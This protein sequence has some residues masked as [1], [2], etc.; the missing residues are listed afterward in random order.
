MEEHGWARS[1]SDSVENDREDDDEFDELDGNDLED[2][3]SLLVVKAFSKRDEIKALLFI[4]KL[5]LRNADQVFKYLELVSEKYIRENCT[6]RILWLVYF[7]RTLL[8]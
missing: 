2:V 5:G 1:K 3:A 6:P 4:Y 7:T 8:G